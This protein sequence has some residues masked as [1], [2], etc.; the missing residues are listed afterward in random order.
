MTLEQ[1]INALADAVADAVKLIKA[2]TTGTLSTTEKNNLIGAINE[3]DTALK[4]KTS[5]IDDTAVDGNVVKTY[6]VDKLLALIE[7]A[8][9]S[10]KADILGGASPA[11]DTLKELQ[12]EISENDTALNALITAT[13]KKVDFTTA[14]TLT[15]AQKAQAC[16]NIGVGNPDSDFAARFTTRLNA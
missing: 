1:R 7:N 10:V 4:S 12:T 3:L 13:N 9:Q 11:Y 2:K 5:V 15:A 16:A 14:Q 8:K 6:S